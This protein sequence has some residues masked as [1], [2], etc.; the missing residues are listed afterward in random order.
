MEKREQRREE[1]L[2]N[3]K[4]F[5]RLNKEILQ[6]V[7]RRKTITVIARNREQYEVVIKPV[8]EVQLLEVGEKY[9]LRLEDIRAGKGSSKVHFMDEVVA[10]GI[11]ERPELSLTKEELDELLDPMERARLFTEIADLS[12]VTAKGKVDLEKFPAKPSQPGP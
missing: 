6:G 7:Q 5:R 4:T 9:D 3:R 11:V 2:E 10:L 8:S 1:I 12:G